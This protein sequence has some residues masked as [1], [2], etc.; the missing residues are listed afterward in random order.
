MFSYFIDHRN[1]VFHKHTAKTCVFKFIFILPLIK[2]NG[3]LYHR[4]L[5]ILTFNMFII[6]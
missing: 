5:I 3:I 1:I 2:E 4:V 6:V